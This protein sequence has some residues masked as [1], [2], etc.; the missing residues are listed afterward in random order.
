VLLPV[1]FVYVAHA[2][3]L[4]HS[5]PYQS[6]NHGIEDV[7]KQIGEC[8]AHDKLLKI[9]ITPNGPPVAAFGQV[10]GASLDLCSGE[11]SENLKPGTSFRT[12]ELPCVLSK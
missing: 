4:E 12:K 5:E 6:S 10:S 11:R 3:S 2:L 8:D 9:S 7:K 1:L